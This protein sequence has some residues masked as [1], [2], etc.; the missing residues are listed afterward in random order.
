MERTHD[1]KSCI[2]AG[3]ID[4]ALVMIAVLEEDDRIVS[5][6]HAAETITGY[7][8]KE[9]IGSNAVWN[10]L[11]PDSDYRNSIW[12][13]IADILKTKNYFEN[14]ETTI[15]MRSGESRTI[16]WNAKKIVLTNLTRTIVVGMDVTTEREAKAFS[17][18]IIDN[19]LVMIMVLGEDDRIVSWNHAAETITGYTQKEVIGSNAVWNNLYPDSDYRNS[20][21]QKIADILKTKN[22]FENIETPIQTRSGQSR[23]ILFNAKK[24]M[25]GGLTRTVVVGMDVTTVR[26]AEA[27]RD[28]I[29]DNAYV[30]IAVIGQQGLILVWNKA[31][32]MITGYSPDEVLGRRDI[33]EKLYP[34]TEYRRNIAQKISRILSEQNY[35]ENFETTILT[36]LRDQRI[37]SWNTRK[38]GTGGKYQEIAIGRDITEQR[39]AEEALIA[40]M[41]EMT[42][43]LK[44]PI[45]IISNTLLESA[46]LVKSGMLSQ[47]EILMVLEGQARNASQIEVNILEFQ[48]AIVEKNR[49]I[50]DAYRKFLKG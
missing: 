16:L 2:E 25:V 35:F 20:I 15:Q 12:Q 9:V 6:N 7:T 1:E 34:D 19:A 39:K 50:P 22:Y 24:V 4:N 5:W 31:A 30:L 41:T 36:K 44:H 33:W 17:D 13:K 45:G 10:D 27:F 21:W 28:T 14:I 47:E 49:S 32:E 18:S 26:E 8:Q 48:T 37:I 46:Q 38:I 43:R 11:Y 29:I 3:I 23:T 40:Y 42:M